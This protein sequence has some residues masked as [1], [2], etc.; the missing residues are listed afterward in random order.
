M[1]DL[2]PGYGTTAGETVVCKEVERESEHDEC[3]A[4]RAHRPRQPGCSATAHPTGSITLLLCPFRHNHHSTGL[5]PPKHFDNCYGALLL[6][7]T[8]VNSPFALLGAAPLHAFHHLLGSGRELIEHL[9]R[10]GK[11]NHHRIAFEVLQHEDLTLITFP[12]VCGFLLGLI[13]A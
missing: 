3:Y 13:I 10:R 11:P 6:P 5:P 7:R 1:W 2:H 8:P 9:G 4:H 12:E